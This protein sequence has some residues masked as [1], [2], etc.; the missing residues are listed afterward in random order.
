MSQN[1][2]IQDMLVAC[3]ELN[4]LY[5]EDDLVLS[6]TTYEMLKPFFKSCTLCYDG[7]EGLDAYK[8]STYDIILT[9]IMMPNLNGKEMSAKIKELNPEQAIIVMSAYEDADHLR[10]LIEIGIHKFVTK[11]PS[12][13]KL[14]SAILS[15][16]IN[17]NNAKQVTQLL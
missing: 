13:D 1:K 10:E 8:I 17:I 7:Q 14:F 6:Q 5:V 16:A 4:L 11:P 3:K 15:S 9:D 2:L 12:I